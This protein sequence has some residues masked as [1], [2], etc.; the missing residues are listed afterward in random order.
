MSGLQPDYEEDEYGNIIRRAPVNYPSGLMNYSPEPEPEPTRGSTLKA[1]T[2]DEGMKKKTERKEAIADTERAV[3]AGR[4]ANAANKL[5]QAQQDQKGAE[6]R[7]TKQLRKTTLLRGQ[8]ED[9]RG[10]G[11]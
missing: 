5:L 7:V 8:G 6:K 11:Q 4:E 1:L 3:K 10:K 9:W 2:D